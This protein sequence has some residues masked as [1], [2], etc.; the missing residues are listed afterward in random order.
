MNLIQ[1][2]LMGAVGGVVVGLIVA[3]IALFFK[4]ASGINKNLDEVKRESPDRKEQNLP[5]DGS[6]KKLSKGTRKITSAIITIML[7][8]YIITRIMVD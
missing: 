1:Y 3:G 4:Y 5:S 2:V 7:L 8:F 6:Q